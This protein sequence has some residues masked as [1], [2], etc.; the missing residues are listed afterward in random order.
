M[1]TYAQYF[2]QDSSQVLAFVS[3]IFVWIAFTALGAAC[4]GAGRIRAFDPLV[5]WAWLGVAFTAAGV[6]FSIPFSLMSVLAGVVASGAGVWVWRRDGGIL[7]SGFMRLLMLIIPLL[8]LITAMRASQWDEFSHWTL[9]PRYM[10]ETDAFPSGG[11]PY[12][13]AGLAAYPFGWNF[14]TYL[15]SRVAGIFLENAGAL[16]NVFLLLMFGLVVLR[17]I[18]QAIEK[19]ELVQKSNWY[20]VSLGGAAVLLANPT[21]SQKIVLTS[22]AETS[23]AVATGAAVILGWLICCALADERELEARH[24]AWQMGAIL[25]LLINLKQAT[26]VLVVLVVL[27]TLFMVIRDSQIS[28]KAF[29]RLLPRVILPAVFIY[30]IWRY[31]VSNELAARELSV[32]SFNDWHFDLIL[33]ILLKMFV[34]LSKKGYYLALV[35]IAVGFGIRGFI[36]SAT[37]FDRFAAIVA[38]VV[39]GYNAF[40]LLTYIAVFE[41]GD[42]LRVASF[43]RYN[44]HLG[45][46][47]VAFSVYGAALLWHRRLSEKWEWRRVKWLPLVVLLIAP[48]IFAKKI[49]FDLAPMIIH[50]R[51]VGAALPELLKPDDRYFVSDPTGSGESGIIMRYEL[52]Q[53]ANFVGIIS[54]FSPKKLE[55]FQ[56]ALERPDLNTILVFSMI[57]E[58]SEALGL[59]LVPDQSYLLR[60]EARGPWRVVE[61][62]PQPA[63]K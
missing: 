21:F 7:P 10:L 32:R 28:T 23:T 39:L 5:G 54:A 8:A 2:I 15:A 57:S 38:M 13:N 61:S 51:M 27:A 52:D 25:A 11:N 30:L 62:W 6:L 19:P 41:K 20:F 60:R 56:A 17:L 24:Y 48:F 58:F 46:M 40:L 50:F 49:R 3:V 31:H 42:G 18:A 45:P 44:M 26:M 22:Y 63:V 14:V 37:P 36:R 59:K 43:W 35:I 9:I 53:A 12:P 4:G 29:F 16:T 55:A 1:M 33:E 47:I 34:V